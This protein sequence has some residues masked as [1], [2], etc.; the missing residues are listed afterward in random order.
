MK[1]RKAR[2]RTKFPQFLT[3]NKTQNALGQVLSLKKQGEKNP[4]DSDKYMIKTNED[5]SI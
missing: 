2:D 4:K 3:N 1:N 5:K